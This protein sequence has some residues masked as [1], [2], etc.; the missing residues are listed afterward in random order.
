M[1]GSA[2]LI[3][4]IQTLPCNYAGE[5][6]FIIF[7]SKLNLNVKKTDLLLFQVFT[8]SIQENQIFNRL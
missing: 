8:N 6:F 3:Y 7:L 4:F 2:I 5:F 1:K